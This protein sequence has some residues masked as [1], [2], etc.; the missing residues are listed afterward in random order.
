[1]EKLIKISGLVD[2]LVDAGLSVEEISEFVGVEVGRVRTL[3]SDG[4]SEPTD[5][6]LGRI[7]SLYDRESVK[8]VYRKHPYISQQ[9]ASEILE[10]SIEDFKAIYGALIKSGAISERRVKPEWAKHEVLERTVM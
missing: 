9:K 3:R 2:G 10:M 5:R 1:M 7:R 8:G 4:A 6:E